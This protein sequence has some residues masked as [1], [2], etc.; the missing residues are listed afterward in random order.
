MG[1]REDGP[2]WEAS[3]GATNRSDQQF[4]R[5]RGQADISFRVS[6]GSTTPRIYGA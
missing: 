6:E 4:Q 2:K 3:D 1:L 5:T